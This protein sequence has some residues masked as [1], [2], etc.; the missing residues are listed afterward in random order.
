M[1]SSQKIAR[2]FKRLD[3]IEGLCLALDL[4]PAGWGT[5]G[6][7]KRSRTCT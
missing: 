6:I 3:H 5:I 1:T 2:A 7:G 4:C